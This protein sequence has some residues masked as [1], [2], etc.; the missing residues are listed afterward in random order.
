MPYRFGRF[1]LDPAARA[2]PH[3]DELRALGAHMSANEACAL[4]FGR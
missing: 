4:G 2:L 3:A 1:E